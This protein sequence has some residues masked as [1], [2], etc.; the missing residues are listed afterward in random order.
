MDRGERDRR[1]QFEGE[2]QRYEEGGVNIK[3]R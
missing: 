3:E 1:R 2:G